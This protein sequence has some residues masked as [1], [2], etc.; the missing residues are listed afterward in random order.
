MTQKADLRRQIADFGAQMNAKQLLL[1]F[2]TPCGR[3]G[4]FGFWKRQLLLAV[5]LLPITFLSHQQWLCFFGYQ[6]Q[7]WEEL[8]LVSALLAQGCPP[9]L[10]ALCVGSHWAQDV[11]NEA[12]LSTWHLW[13][14]PGFEP[15]RAALLVLFTLL[16]LLICWSSFSLLLRRLRDL[17]L[18]LWLLPPCLPMLWMLPLVLCFPVESDVEGALMVVATLLILPL[19]AAFSLICTSV[20]GRTAAEEE[21]KGEE[22]PLQPAPSDIPPQP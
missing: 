8:R 13:K 2:V 22:A 21:Q 4:R 9:V 20:P 6:H 18:G 3:I 10:L 15:L 5:L 11:F 17:K 16:E 7:E 12:T 14:A 19:P 1:S